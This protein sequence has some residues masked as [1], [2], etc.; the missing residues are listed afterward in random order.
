[1]AFLRVQFKND[2]AKEFTLDQRTTSIG[3]NKDN[4][5]VI[6]SPGV[7]GQHA[8]IN[9]EDNFFITDL[10]STN[11]TYINGKKILHHKLTDGDTIAIAGFPI[12]F[13]A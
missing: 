9:F 7:S 13:Y 5:I 3:R 11:G 12:T 8:R 4:N 1:M 6:E 10:R 2:V